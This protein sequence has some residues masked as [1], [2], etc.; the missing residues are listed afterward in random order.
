MCRQLRPDVALVDIRMPRLDG[1]QAARRITGDAENRTAVVMLTTFDADEH[2]VE[3]L[4][5]EPPGSCSS[6]C[7]GSSWSPPSGPPSAATRCWRP[8]CCVASSTTSW[9]APGHR[10]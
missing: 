7:R 8:R 6:R 9:V 10:W 3:A 2:V 5:A 4:R 1:I